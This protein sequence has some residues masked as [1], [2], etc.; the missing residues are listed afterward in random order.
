MAAAFAAAV[1]QA[2]VIK[3]AYIDGVTGAFAPLIKNSVDSF[4]FYID[5]AN[6]QKWAGNNTFELVVLD[7]KVSPQESLRQL[8]I[9]SDQGIRYV[10]HQVGSGVALALVDAINKFNERNPGK[11]MVYF[12]GAAID[13]DLT[14]S[15]CSFWHF[16]FDA[17]TDQKMEGITN[18]LAKDPSIKKVYII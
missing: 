18:V 8:K 5:Q 15:K 7:G 12:N 3:I 17:N 16:R 4:E 13:P 9:A 10:I 6:K 1:A 11:E 2:E 14:N